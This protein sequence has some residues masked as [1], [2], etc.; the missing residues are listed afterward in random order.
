MRKRDTIL[1]RV[2]GRVGGIAF[3]GR[4]RWR[5]AR[6]VLAEK[7]KLSP[8]ELVRLRVRYYTDGVV[9]GSKDFVEG[10]LDSQRERFGPKRNQGARRMAESDSPFYSLRHLPVRPLG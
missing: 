3:W 7:G 9:L 4:G 8:A 2:L 6:A 5:S 1:A 10:I